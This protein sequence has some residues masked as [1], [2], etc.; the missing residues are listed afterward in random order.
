MISKSNFLTIYGQAHLCTL[1]SETIMAA[2]WKTD[3]WPFNHNVI[4][5]EAM[6][7][8]KETS[9]EAHLPAVVAPE[10][11]E[12]V[13]LLQDL[14]INDS[15]DM[16]EIQHIHG[17]KRYVVESG[18]EDGDDEEEDMGDGGCNEVESR[19]DKNEVT[20]TGIDFESTGS[21]GNSKGNSKDIGRLTETVPMIRGPANTIKSVI[22]NLSNGSLV[23]L[24]S[25]GP[26]ASTSQIPLSAAQ[27][28][29][30]I[31]MSSKDFTPKTKSKKTI[32][33]APQECEK[34]EAA[35]KHCLMKVQALD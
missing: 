13:K 23:Y 10:I 8:S 33:V 7:A 31:K 3:I 34:H 18:E 16:E 17:D 29:L 30:P 12:L 19:E 1:T 20:R 5:P 11:H 35:L 32:F 22:K 15:C 4:S 26:V 28:I 6:A 21:D 2:F 24:V 9:C 27:V 14:S 25:S